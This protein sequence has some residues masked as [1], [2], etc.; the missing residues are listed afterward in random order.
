MSMI[1]A[2]IAVD[3][4]TEVL[5]RLDDVYHQLKQ[6]VPDRTVRWVPVKNIHL[7]L[8]FLGDVSESNLG[9]LYEILRKEAEKQATFDIQVSGLGAFPSTNRPHVLWAGVQAPPDLAALQRA[10]DLETARIGYTSEDRDFSPHLTLGRVTRNATPEEA[11]R[12]GGALSNTQTGYLGTCRIKAVNFYR[13]DL[14]PQGSIYT[15]LYTAP[16]K[17]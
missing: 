13:S 8:K 11:R 1:R 2:F 9:V 5:C 10:I 16:F 14:N 7:T 3:L 6:R 15:R 4:S 12:V 17:P